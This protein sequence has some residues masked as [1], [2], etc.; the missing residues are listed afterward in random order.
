MINHFLCKQSFNV[1]SKDIVIYGPDVQAHI[2]PNFW[3][4]S[5]GKGTTLQWN[6]LHNC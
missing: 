3:N 6:T 4:V 1:R 2:A 5:S